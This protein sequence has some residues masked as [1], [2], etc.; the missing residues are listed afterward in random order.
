M[1]KNPLRKGF[2]RWLAQR[3]P[4]A[5]TL[6][7]DQRRIF[8]FPS[9]QGGVFT[10]LLIL[11]LLV[12]INYQ[13][14]LAFALTFLLISLFIVAILHTYSN[15]AGLQINAGHTRV[16]F[17]GERAEFEVILARHPKRRHYG[18]QLGWVDSST[19][20][21]DLA[22]GLDRSVKLYYRTYKR[23][24]RKAGRLRIQS[25]YPLGLLRCWTWVDLDM[26]SLVYPKPIAN[27]RPHKHS[28]SIHNG[29][30][31]A[32][33]GTE[34]F[35]GFRPYVAGDPPKHLSWRGVAKGQALLTKQFS[36]N[37]DRRVWLDWEDYAGEPVEMRLSKLCYWV[38][39]LAKGEDHFGLRLPG[40]EIK[41]GHG[42]AHK[43]KLLRALALF[44][45]AAQDEAR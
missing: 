9:L 13:N 40:S 43:E 7:L 28:F 19:A 31:E 18:L 10:F 23:G 37:A 33:S 5:R 45:V 12:G 21:I 25:Y 20:L 11:L 41:P 8:I 22:D 15:L 1:R 4:A 29:D 27:I 24:W 14:N 35:Y 36:D 42:D 6:T 34:D 44:D 39:E 3:I 30:L 16:A 38:L 2:K 17:A 26:R 32:R